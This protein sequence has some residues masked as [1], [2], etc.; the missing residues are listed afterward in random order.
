[1]IGALVLRP[2]PGNAATTAR[3]T[4]NG[5]TVRSCPLFAVEPVTWTP[6][7]PVGF[8]SLLL[9]SANA[10]RHAGPALRALAGLPVLA[11]GTATAAAAERAGLS[12][13][14]T[15]TT[16]AAALLAQARARGW[17]RSL[18]LAGEDRHDLPDV[19]T[20]T[21]YR[22]A[23]LSIAPAEV[24]AWVDHVALLHSPRAARRFADL[25]DATSTRASIAVAAL[26][27]AVA[28]AAGSGWREAV[29]AEH[30][31]D[32]LLV[33]ATAAMID[34]SGPAADKRA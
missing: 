12:V 34:R 32:D 16:H 28:D 17:R 21:V 10:V 4:A 20:I 33:A 22:S 8:D 19:S 14:L 29:T 3:L 24:A 23:A 31:R 27:P 6:P 7:D 1:M 9:T 25:A 30:P 2:E 26:S 11:V 15:G 18:H 5:M 13:A